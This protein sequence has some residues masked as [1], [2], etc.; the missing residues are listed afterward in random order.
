MT[1]RPDATK[2]TAQ[3]EEAMQTTQGTRDARR[4]PPLVAIVGSAGCR[5]S[6][7]MLFRNLPNDSGMAFVICTRL[8]SRQLNALPNI[9]QKRTAMPVVVAADGVPLQ[10]D[11]VYVAP[12][13]VQLTVEKGAVRLQSLDQLADTDQ[14]NG[15]LDRFLAS[16]AETDQQERAAILLSGTGSDGTAGL[17]AVEAAG[18]LVLIQDPEEA[19]HGALPRRAV[20]ACPNAT[21]ATAGELARRL[22]QQQGDLVDGPPIARAEVAESFD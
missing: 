21:V 12:V 16:L 7:E 5:Q 10:A 19:A 8:G 18:G 6:L 4:A 17:A 13:A 14:F 15:P 11:R 2:D 3:P 20:A 22:I 9:L 1:N